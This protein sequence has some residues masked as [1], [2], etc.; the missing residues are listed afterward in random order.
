[1]LSTHV[2]IDIHINHQS[3]LKGVAAAQLRAQTFVEEPWNER[4]VLVANL[5]LESMEQCWEAPLF[6]RV[7]S[8]EGAC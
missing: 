5:L 6:Q 8:R 3:W 4:R 7:G 2:Q 1:M